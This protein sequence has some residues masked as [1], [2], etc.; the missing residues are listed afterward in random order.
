MRIHVSVLSGQDH[1]ILTIRTPTLVI[2]PDFGPELRW[3]SN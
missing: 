3:V 2:D 1:G